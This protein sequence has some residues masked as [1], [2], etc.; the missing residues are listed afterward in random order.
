MSPNEVFFH[1]SAA[2]CGGMLSD[3]FENEKPLYKNLIENLAKQRKLRPVF[4]ERKARTERFAWIKDALG[5]KQNE[6]V[7]ANLLQ[8][9]LVSRHPGMLCDF[10]DSLGIKHDDNGTVEAMPPQPEKP[11]L[12]AAIAALLE[13]YDPAIVAVYLH[14][15]QAL[16]DTGWPLIDEIIAADPRLHLGAPQPQT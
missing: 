12:E 4:I 5:R 14:A 3:L 13:K 16:D 6:P 1:M 15:F 7:A 10:L 2:T 8:I 9:W 11:A